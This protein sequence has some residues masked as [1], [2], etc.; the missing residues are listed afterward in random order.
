MS[1]GKFPRVSNEDIILLR[2]EILVLSPRVKRLVRGK[3]FS[4]KE[5]EALGLSFPLV[6]KLGLPVDE[7]RKSMHEINIDLL[8]R[9]L[10]KYGIT[11]PSAKPPISEIAE[12]AAGV[13]R[14]ALGDVITKIA[15]KLVEF[16]DTAKRREIRKITEVFADAVKEH[17][18]ELLNKLDDKTIESIINTLLEDLSRAGLCSVTQKY[19]TKG[20]WDASV[21]REKILDN[22]RKRLLVM[23]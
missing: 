11:L 2:N 18:P 20:E 14:R 22:L 9:I 1:H 5:I 17:A 12:E 16:M 10:E 13:T 4:R 21:A 19:F 8:R 6:K 7:R 15:E 3:G 23:G